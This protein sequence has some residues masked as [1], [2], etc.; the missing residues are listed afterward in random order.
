LEGE[1]TIDWKQATCRS[2]SNKRRHLIVSM[3]FEGSVTAQ[4]SHIGRS[5]PNRGEAVSRWSFA[6][7]VVI[8]AASLLKPREKEHRDGW[9]QNFPEISPECFKGARD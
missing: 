9:F 4:F 7:R 3:C 2:F 1:A 5:F 6:L 8:Q